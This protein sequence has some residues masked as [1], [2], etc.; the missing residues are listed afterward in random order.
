MAIKRIYFVRHG[1]TEGNV[2]RFLQF[3]D[4]PLTQQ[5]HKGAE[6]IAQRLVHVEVDTLIASSFLRAQQTAGYIS[7]VKKLPITTVESFHESM[8]PAAYRGLGMDS[9]EVLKFRA[10]YRVNY[11]RGDWHEEGGENY[12][13]VSKRVVE[14]IE[15]LEECEGQEIAVVSHGD[16]IRSIT[17]YLLL[18]KDTDVV[19]NKAVFTSLQLMSNAAITEFT[20][21]D[22]MWKLFTWNDHAHF[23]E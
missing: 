15:Y 14:S 8:R 18:Q 7:E 13:D 22:G 3:H 20:F 5:G 23:A 17:S 21:E 16:F 12:F 4:T 10:D 19:A 2:K 6:A 11:W 9:D 1:E